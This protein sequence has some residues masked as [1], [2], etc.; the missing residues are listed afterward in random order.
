MDVTVVIPT[1]DRPDLLA[2]TL[3]TVLWQQSVQT[4][5]LVVD[6]GEEPGTAEL[7]RQ[8]G[9]SRVRLLRNSNPRESAGPAT[10]VSQHRGESGSPSW[11]M[12]TSGLHA[13][14]PRS[15][16]WQRHPAPRGCTPVM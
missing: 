16:P 13:N 7:V 3:R 1:R 5:I 15:L 6:D 2:L 14:L 10:W 8:V 11:M 9:D 12:T 4:E